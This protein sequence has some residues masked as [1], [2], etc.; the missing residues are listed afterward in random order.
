M[1][2]YA[3]KEAFSEYTKIL[4]GTSKEEWAKMSDAEKRKINPVTKIMKP[5]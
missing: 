3:K 1:G 5:V 2:Y 4:K